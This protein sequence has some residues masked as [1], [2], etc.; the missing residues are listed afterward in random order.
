MSSGYEWEIYRDH[1]QEQQH[2]DMCRGNK[3]Q[4]IGRLRSRLLL[5]LPSP[6]SAPY[7]WLYRIH[8]NMHYAAAQMQK[9]ITTVNCAL[10]RPSAV[11]HARCQ[12][13]IYEF[14]HVPSSCSRVLCWCSKTWAQCD[15]PLCATCDR[16]I[17]SRSATST[18]CAADNSPS[19]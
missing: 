15:A 9:S 5:R 12:L 17:A 11:S 13:A 3:K 14:M 1:R 18:G 8:A 6:P 10:D 16:T 19:R 2:V 4:K 7:F